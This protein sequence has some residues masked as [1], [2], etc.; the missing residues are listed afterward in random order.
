MPYH[1]IT[2]DDKLVGVTT[3]NAYTFNLPDVSIHEFDGSVP[4]LNTYEWNPAVDEFTLASTH[5]T[6]L[7]FLNRF[8]ME[9]RINIRSSQN[10]IVI[11]I[12]NLLEVAENISLT[13]PTTINSI[14]YLAYV[15]LIAPT[16]VAEILA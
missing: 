15:G 12:M 16:R 11:D 1:V 6:K 10:P 2:R 14:G 13:D 9:E 7:G 4:D 8:T 5:V 3:E